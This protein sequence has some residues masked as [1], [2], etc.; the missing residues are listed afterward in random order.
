MEGDVSS[1]VYC[2]VCWRF[3]VWYVRWILKLNTA[4]LFEQRLRVDLTHCRRFGW[5]DEKILFS[6]RTNKE[7]SPQR[8]TVTAFI[9]F[10]NIVYSQT[11]FVWLFVTNAIAGVLCHH[12]T[13]RQNC[14][15]RSHPSDFVHSKRLNKAMKHGIFS[16]HRWYIF[17]G[18]RELWFT[19]VIIS[20]A[21]WRKEWEKNPSNPF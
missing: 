7:T 1:L 15:I 11:P 21:T 9:C 12:F 2:R 17:N 10:T 13:H 3:F 16:Y 6:Y 4:A 18:I 5:R 8:L 19:F 14:L 20:R